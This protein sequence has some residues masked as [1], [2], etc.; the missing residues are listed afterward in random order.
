MTSVSVA[1]AKDQLSRLIRQAETGQEVQLTRRGRPVA[2]L[3]G[4]AAWE[5]LRGDGVAFAERY[6]RFRESHDL[7][8][9][10]IDPDEIYSDTRPQTTGRDFGW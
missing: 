2:V 3:L 5:E 7:E 9:L 6:R 1:E 8:A 4:H 10:D